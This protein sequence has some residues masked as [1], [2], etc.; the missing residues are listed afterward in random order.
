[1]GRPPDP[2]MRLHTGLAVPAVSVSRGRA[3]ASAG[4]SQSGSAEERP[5]Q[6]PEPG[7]ARPHTEDF[8]DL[9]RG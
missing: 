9:G 5:M 8:I 6:P 4:L 7:S 2:G 3:T 1:M